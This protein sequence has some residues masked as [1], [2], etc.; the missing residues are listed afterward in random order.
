[1]SPFPRRSGAPIPVSCPLNEGGSQRSEAGGSAVRAHGDD[2]VRR[3]RFGRSGTGAA[4]S[5]RARPARRIRRSVALTDAS[6]RHDHEAHGPLP[7]CGHRPLAAWRAHAG[8]SRHQRRRHRVRR[9][10]DRIRMALA[11]PARDD[12]RGYGSSRHDRHVHLPA[13]GAD[14][15]G[16]VPTSDPARGR[17]DHMARGW[18][19]AGRP[20]ERP[21]LPQQRGRGLTPFR[22]A[23]RRRQHAH[24][25]DPQYGGTHLDEGSARTAG[26]PRRRR[27]RQIPRRSRRRLAYTRPCRDPV[28]ADRDPRRPCDVHLPRS[29]TQSSRCVSVAVA[30]RRRRRDLAGGRRRRQPHHR[31]R[32]R[33]AD[34]ARTRR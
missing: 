25:Q 19:A 24:R 2:R 4:W 16:R 3:G 9:T 33:C 7:E 21:R 23:S 27:R 18:R 22:A 32:T 8:Q 11:Q 34:D 20:D 15:S 17:R 6:S 1:M 5:Q 14:G 10:G 29:R 30:P 13:A 31:G 26:E 28:R 12:I